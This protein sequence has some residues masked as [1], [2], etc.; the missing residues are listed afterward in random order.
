MEQRASMDEKWRLEARWAE[1]QVFVWRGAKGELGT[2]PWELGEA[3]LGAYESGDRGMEVVECWGGIEDAVGDE[4]VG[5]W[6][7][8]DLTLDG[9]SEW[10]GA[11]EWC[12]REGVLDA[13]EI[14]W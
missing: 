7:V 4:D 2:M 14:E 13:R 10:A 9:K 6:E 1:A 8:G 5:E 3:M 12:R 11:V